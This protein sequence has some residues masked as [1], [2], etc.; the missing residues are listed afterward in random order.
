[1]DRTEAQG[2]NPFNLLDPQLDTADLALIN[3]EMAISDRGRAVNKRFVFRAPSSAAGRIAQAGI[4]VATLANNHARDYGSEALLDTVDWLEAA[5]VVTVGAGANLDEAHQHKVLTAGNGVRVAFVGASMIVPGGFT[6]GNATAGI[7]SLYGS[8][9][10]RTFAAIRAAAD[11][12]DVVIATVHWGIERDTCPS[13]TQETMAR[14][15]L[16]AGADAVIGHHPHVIQPVEFYD[17][18]LIAYSLGNF[19][20]HPRRGIA[21]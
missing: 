10:D 15:L 5:G 6:A 18:K 17:R 13:V 19:V 4:D 21:G 1:M 3:V 9:A 8:S 12:A 20:W 2:I 11:E 7:A 14:E 16:S